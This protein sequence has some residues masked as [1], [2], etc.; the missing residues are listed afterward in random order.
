MKMF[1]KGRKSLGQTTV[2]YAIII[3]LM[4]MAAIVAYMA[5]GT[6]MQ[7]LVRGQTEALSGEEGV[8]VDRADTSGISGPSLSDF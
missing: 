8:Q 7:F 2:E 4:A 6:Q 3:A 5:L 1:R